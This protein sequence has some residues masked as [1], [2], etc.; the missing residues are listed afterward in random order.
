MM[1]VPHSQ[2][3]EGSV[4]AGA[5]EADI[6]VRA[7]NRLRREGGN[8]IASVSRAALSQSTFQEEE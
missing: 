5:S 8:A 6:A 1:L 4:V 2:R 3:D 7:A